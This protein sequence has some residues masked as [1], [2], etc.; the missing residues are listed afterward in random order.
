MNRKDIDRFFAEVAR[1]HRQ[2]L[3]IYLTGGIASW[4]LGGN[5]PTRDIDFAVSDGS[6]ELTHKL[7][8]VSRDLGIP[9]QYSDDIQRWGMINVP[10]IYAGAIRHKKFGS[11][12][13]Y[14]LA[15]EKWAIGKLNRYLESDLEDLVA[16]FRKKKPDLQ[17]TLEYWKCALRESPASTQ[18]GLFKQQVNHFLKHHGKSIWGKTCPEKLF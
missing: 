14:L 16:V 2:P 7:D 4:F 11:V 15:P 17:K 12:T 9:I 5:R 8:Q 3:D 6:E 10:D 1:L 13:V 18:Q